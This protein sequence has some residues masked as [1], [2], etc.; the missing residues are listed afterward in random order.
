M[1]LILD[2]LKSVG[3]I[4]LGIFS[5]MVV[6][7]MFMWEALKLFGKL[8]AWMINAKIQEKYYPEEKEIQE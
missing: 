3:Y 8:I 7:L 1:K 6:V 5:I 4:M 2:G